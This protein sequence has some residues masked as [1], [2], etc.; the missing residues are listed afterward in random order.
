LHHF[1]AY[2]SALRMHWSL[3]T[4]QGKRVRSSSDGFAAVPIQGP[5]CTVLFAKQTSPPDLDML[6]GMRPFNTR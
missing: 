2:L 4:G 5:D 6:T 3:A 1:A